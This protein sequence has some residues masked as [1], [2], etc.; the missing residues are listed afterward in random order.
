MTAINKIVLHIP[1]ASI[2]GIFGPYGKW[3]R[4]PHFINECVNRWT[5]WYTDML[6]ATTNEKV[7]NA[8]FPY[9]CFVCDAERLDN[10]PMEAQGQGI[11]Y[12]HFGGYDR[13]MLTTMES[14]FLYNQR[15]QHLETVRSL[16]TPDSL[17]IDCHSFPG[18]L[19][20]ID[21][22][23][24]YNDDWSKP[25]DV[26]IDAVSK[27]FTELGY[28]V[29]INEPYSNSYSPKTE[30]EYKSLMIE[31][32]KNV[33]LNSRNEIDGFFYKKNAIMQGLYRRLFNI[34]T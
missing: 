18:D 31:V 7:A 10:D 23:I 4:N 12:Q 17:L 20:D 5:D 21:F 16:L 1:H 33:Y 15:K 25:D 29:G 8:I 28:K 32:N 3:P 19:S 11:L 26:V 14:E 24:G 13:G 34:Y 27:Y 9:S 2:N 6:F 22:C 30:Y